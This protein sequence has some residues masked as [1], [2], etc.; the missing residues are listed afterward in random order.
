[1]NEG[2]ETIR[3]ILFYSV[4]G[5][6]L[7]AGRIFGGLV[8]FALFLVASRVFRRLL[9]RQVLR[10]FRVEEPLERTILGG[11]HYVILILGAWAAMAFAGAN[12]DFLFYSVKVG[13]AQLSLALVLGAVLLFVIALL[14]SRVIRWV[15][16]RRVFPQFRIE[17]GLEYTILRVLHYLIII[18]GAW[19]ALTFAGAN[20]TGLTVVAGLMSVGIGFGLQNVA[21]NFISGVILLFERP[22]KVG[23]RITVGEVVGDVRSIN[24]RSTRVITLDNISIIVPNSEFVS[25]RVVNWSHGDRKVRVHIPVG[26]AYGSDVERVTKALR[27]EG[28]RHPG[29]LR[30][31]EPRVWFVGFGDSSL[32]FELLV[33]IADPITQPQTISDLNYAI[34]AAFRRNEI[35]IPFP[36]RDLHVRD[37]LPL[38]LREVSEEEAGG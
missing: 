37:G 18:L 1:M 30:A 28:E 3:H 15:L 14:I 11:V 25:G 27:E 34:D 36:Q 19:T 22:I 26:V 2:L 21:S 12:L 33:W 35:Q 20:L 5:I 24:L 16:G 31:P 17:S 7:P 13:E 10:R 4:P 29:V 38:R 9:S 8:L 6:D 32:N 23:D